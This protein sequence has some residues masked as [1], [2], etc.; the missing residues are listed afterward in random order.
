MFSFF[1]LPFLLLIPNL[2]LLLCCFVFNV[3]CFVLLTTFP[4]SPSLLLRC[5]L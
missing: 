1:L 4:L 5:L 2:F 3:H